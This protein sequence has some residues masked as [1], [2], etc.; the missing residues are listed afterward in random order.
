MAEKSR[1]LV[2]FWGMFFKVLFFFDFCLFFG[3]ILGATRVPKGMHFGSQNRAKIDQKRGANLR[4]KKSPLGVVLV[5]F[6]VDV[7]GVLGSKM[8]IFHCF[9]NGFVNIH[10]FDKDECPRAIRDQKW[11]KNGAKLAPKWV[12]KR[13]KNRSKNM[14]DFLIDFEALLEPPSTAPQPAIQRAGPVEGGRGEA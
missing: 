5:R 10:V 4:A 7:Q 3:A 14:M 13:I 9:L 6:C 12:P 2:F 11:S 1:C 8:L